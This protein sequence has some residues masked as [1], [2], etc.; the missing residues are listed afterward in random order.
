[1][2]LINKKIVLEDDNWVIATNADNLP[3]DGNL[4]VDID[5]W[6]QHKSTLQA[7][8]GEVGLFIRSSDE[9]TELVQDLSEWS[10][11]AIDFP[12]APE[13]IPFDGRGYSHARTLRDRFHYKGE[14]RAVGIV[15]RDHLYYMS[16]VGF[17]TFQLPDGADTDNALT[18]FDEFSVKYQAAADEDLPLYR[19]HSR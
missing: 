9:I 18:A 13:G 4:F 16:R 10:V 7:R 12:Q 3:P 19:R 8:S 1:M 17:D 15:L 2:P 11:I 14:L 5:L 6:N